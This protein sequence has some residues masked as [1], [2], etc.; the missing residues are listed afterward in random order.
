MVQNLVQHGY[1]VR[2][3][4][5]D[6]SRLDKVAHL[7]DMGSKGPGS[8]TLYDCDMFVDGA[9]DEAFKGV[10]CVYHVAAELGSTEGAT[11]QS[12]YDGGMVATQKV[13]DS[14]IK[15]GAPGTPSVQRFIFT[16]SFAAVGHPGAPAL[17]GPRLTEADWAD[18]NTP[19]DWADNVAYDRDIAYAKTK[20]DTERLCYSE[21][22]KHGFEAFGVMPCHVLGPLLCK[23]HGK[24]YAQHAAQYLLSRGRPAVALL[25]D[26]QL[27][28][29]SVLQVYVADTDRRHA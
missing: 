20:A 16:S 24:P 14:V 6:S 21:A 7:V 3:C 15:S 27:I 23:D 26:A 4:V 8:V 5:R 10:T 17:G 25:Q 12:V 28:L 19:A 22:E 9:Y 11:P 18:M 1:N 2:A 29:S 13:L